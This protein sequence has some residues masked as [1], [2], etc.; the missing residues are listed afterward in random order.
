MDRYRVKKTGVFVEAAQLTED[1][2]DKI[3]NWTQGQIVEEIDPITGEQQEGIN[4]RTR[5]GYRTRLS[6]GAYV[7]STVDSFL[8]VGA[9]AF[10]QLYEKVGHI[11]DP[12]GDVWNNP[13]DKVNR[14]GKPSTPN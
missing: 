8:V 12:P 5:D 1:N 14:V 2:V 13:F 4:V 6:R 9:S 3:A 7:I 11:P 10:D